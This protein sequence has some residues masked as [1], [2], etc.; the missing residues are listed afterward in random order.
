MY[1]T[2]VSILTID[3]GFIVTSDY[4]ELNLIKYCPTLEL[5]FVEIKEFMKEYLAPEE[6]QNVG[7]IPDN[8][9]GEWDSN[10]TLEMKS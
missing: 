9:L 1:G 8:P 2:K 3:N 5:C 10:N 6:E 4:P 7:E